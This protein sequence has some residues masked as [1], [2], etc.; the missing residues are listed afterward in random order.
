MSKPEP[1]NIHNLPTED[2]PDGYGSMMPFD[3][4]PNYM[5]TVLRIQ[6]DAETP[7]MKRRMRENSAN[8]IKMG[9]LDHEKPGTPYK[10]THTIDTLPEPPTKK[11]GKRDKEQHPSSLLTTIESE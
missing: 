5:Q 7:D 4:L 3:K 8:W 1:Y 11:G 10:R 2:P 6:W 9:R